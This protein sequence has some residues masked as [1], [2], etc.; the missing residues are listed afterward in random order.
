MILQTCDERTVKRAQT[1]SEDPHRRERKFFLS[2]SLL[3]G[4]LLILP[5]GILVGF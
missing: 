5:E 1:G 2:L 4:S 3:P